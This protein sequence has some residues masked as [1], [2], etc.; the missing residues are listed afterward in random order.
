MDNI[1]NFFFERKT[2]KKT[3]KTLTIICGLVFFSTNTFANCSAGTF[4]GSP[5]GLGGQT[6]SCNDGS[7]FTYR[8]GG[9]GG[10]S[11]T[12]NQ[13]GERYSPSG[14]SSRKQEYQGLSGRT[15]NGPNDSLNVRRGG[16]GGDQ[17]NKY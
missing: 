11:I 5:E 4:S 2:M 8:G 3:F 12:N 14:L 13:T 1:I 7:S 9:I 16:L 10:D 15:F 17:I 6:F